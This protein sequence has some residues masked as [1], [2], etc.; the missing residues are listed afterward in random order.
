MEPVRE[1]DRGTAARRSALRW[2]GVGGLDGTGQP[3]PPT[4]LIGRGRGRDRRARA[5]FGDDLAAR[6]ARRAPL[7]PALEPA[8]VDLARLVSRAHEQRLAELDRQGKLLEAQ[9]LRMR[10]TYDIEMMRQVGSCSGIENYSRHIDGREAGSAPNCLL[11]YFPEDFVLVVDESHVTIPQ[12]GGMYEGDM[13][14][15]RTLVD[16][17]FRLPSAMDNR[18][19]RFEEFTERIGQTVYLSATPGPYELARSDGF[20]EQVIRPTGLIDPPVEVRPVSANNAS[21]VD[22]VIAGLLVA[23][24]FASIED[25]VAVDDEDHAGDVVPLGLADILVEQLGALDIEEVG[26]ADLVA[27]L[28]GD[29]AG[30]GGRNGLGED[31]EAPGAPAA[32]AARAASYQ[33]RLGIRASLGMGNDVIEGELG[34]LFYRISAIAAGATIPQVDSQSFFL[35]DPVHSHPLFGTRSGFGFLGAVGGWFLVHVWR[36]ILFLLMVK[37]KDDIS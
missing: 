8:A 26:L 21:Q 29:L 3:L 23:E 22:D 32:I 10:T 16:F 5:V 37:L 34:P 18:P 19:L 7:P 31:R 35:P 2:Q 36:L 11:D 4:D 14:R 6:R 12:I 27:G 28:L 20:V 13:S 1:P 9:R 30:Q 15:K 17:G 24:G 33:V 25:L